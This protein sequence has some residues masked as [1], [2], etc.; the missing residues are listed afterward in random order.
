M[1]AGALP[2]APTVRG[3]LPL[4]REGEDGGEAA[5]SG[6]PAS[7]LSSENAGRSLSVWVL[8]VTAMDGCGAW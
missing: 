7:W 5:L 4:G 1:R 8:V 2:S 3:L 6:V